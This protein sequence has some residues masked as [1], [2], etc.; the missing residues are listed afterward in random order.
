M[1]SL[2]PSTEEPTFACS[3]FWRTWWSD[4]DIRSR[5]LDRFERLV[6]LLLF[7]SFFHALVV[8]IGTA[9]RFGQSVAISD[10]MLLITETMMVIMV[11]FR[12]RA[13]NLSLN[14]TDWALAFSATCLSLLARPFPGP[15]HSWSQFAVLLT[16]AGVSIQ[17]VSKM[18]LGRRFGVVAANRGICMSGPYRFVRHPIYMGYIFLHTGFVLLNPHIWNFAVFALLYCLQ[19]PRILAEER[20]LVQDAEYK[21]YTHKVRYRLLPGLF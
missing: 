10:F 3:D 4:A 12:R 13:K 20:L 7:G 16:I 1:Q 9:I 21:A 18:T 17:L 5:G 15:L 6:I 19:I 11:M 2:N 14:V 8:S